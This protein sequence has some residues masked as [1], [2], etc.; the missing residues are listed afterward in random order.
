MNAEHSELMIDEWGMM[1]GI[2]LYMPWPQRGPV[3]ETEL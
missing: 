3:V 2:V 1:P